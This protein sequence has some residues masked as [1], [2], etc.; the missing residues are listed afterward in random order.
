MYLDLRRFRYFY[1]KTS[2]NYRV[3]QQMLLLKPKYPLKCILLTNESAYWVIFLGD[4]T[5][6]AL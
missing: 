2:E 4:V 6:L 3:R 5:D 1:S